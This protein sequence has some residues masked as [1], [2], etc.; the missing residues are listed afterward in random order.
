[1]VAKEYQVTTGEAHEPIPSVIR[2][3]R[4]VIDPHELTFDGAGPARVVPSDLDTGALKRCE[5]DLRPT[6]R[7]I[8]HP[9]YS[10]PSGRSPRHER[11]RPA[12]K[13]LDRDFLQSLKEA[14]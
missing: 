5:V 2:D 11:A 3:E 7:A 6:E 1:M 12:S 8:H 14:F 9:Q 13:R 10:R 4:P